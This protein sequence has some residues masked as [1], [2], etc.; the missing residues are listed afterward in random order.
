[1]KFSLKKMS[2]FCAI[3]F[4]QVAHAQ[5]LNCEVI[6]DS[7]RVQTQE[8]GIIQQMQ[9]DIS[10]FMNTQQWTNQVY[11]EHER[12]KCTIFLNLSGSSEVN[13]GRYQA[14]V[15]IQSIRP[16]HGTQYETPLINFFDKNFSFIYQPSQPLI[17]AENVFTN[18]LT[19]TL[20]FYAYTILAIDSDTFARMGGSKYYEKILEI[21]NNA[22][23]SGGGGWSDGDTRNR[24]WISENMNSPQFIPFREVLYAYHRLI[25]DDFLTNTDEKRQ[26]L[27]KLLGE[28][29]KV[30]EI[31]PTAI[32]IN[33]FFDAKANELVDMFSQGDEA[34]RQQALDILVKLDPTNTTKYRK[35]LK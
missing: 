20:A 12:I 14:T 17:F 6:I 1:M 16:V 29:R 15:Q 18:N 27:V 11:Q 2:L 5:E 13:Q 28:I 23:Q 34:I 9:K 35:I 26:E 10:K 31:R 24:Y 8:Q 21:V 30:Q 25:L 3:L 22:R 32:M 33:M 4:S 7:E 19:A